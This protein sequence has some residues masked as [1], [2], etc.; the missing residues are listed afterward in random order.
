[1]KTAL[2]FKVLGTGALRQRDM[3]NIRCARRADFGF[4]EPDVLTYSA[5]IDAPD[6]MPA[7]SVGVEWCHDWRGV[8]IASQRE[9]HRED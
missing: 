5:P 6:Y 8:K 1:V 4:I 3:A 9:V 7:G 2:Q